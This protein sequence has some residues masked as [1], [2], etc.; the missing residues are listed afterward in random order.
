MASYLFTLQNFQVLHFVAY[1]LLQGWH[2]HSTV[3]G[4]L[5]EHAK[6]LQHR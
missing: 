1:K 3:P 2:Y 4:L 6:C 5:R